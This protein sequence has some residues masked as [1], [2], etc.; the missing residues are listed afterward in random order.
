MPAQGVPAEK[1]SGASVGTPP[2]TTPPSSKAAGLS[3]RIPDPS[4]YGGD[5]ED[6]RRFVSQIRAKMNVN[7]DRFPAPQSRMTYVISRLSGAT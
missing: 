1:A 3:E 7:Q 4:E 2:S 5:R 6:L